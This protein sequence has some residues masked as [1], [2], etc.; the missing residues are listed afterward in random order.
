MI[1]YQ[2]KLPYP[3][4]I[5]KDKQDEKYKKFLDMFKTLHIN[6]PFMEALAQMPRYAKFLKELLTKKNKLEEVSSLKLSE[7]CSALI[8]NKLPKKKKDPGG[9]IVPCTIE[10]LVDEKA[11]ADLGTSINLMLYKIFQKLGLGEPKA[12]TMMLQ[13]ADRSIRQPRGII[14]DVLV[15]VVKFIF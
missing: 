8:C 14:K 7:E 2:P 12:T 4:K 5:K 10:G 13:L 15:K 9:F 3:V 1:E 11:L 6:V